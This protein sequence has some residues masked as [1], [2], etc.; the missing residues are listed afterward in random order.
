MSSYLSR[1][2]VRSALQ[3]GRNKFDLS[4][5]HLTTQDFYNMK[6]VYI[7][8]CI[9]GEKIHINMQAFTRLSPL[10]QPMLGS[11]RMVNRAFF[12]PMRTVIKFVHTFNHNASEWNL[13]F[14]TIDIYFY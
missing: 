9:P 13:R 3:R 11:V 12:V 2:K 1:I 10:V 8:E 14:D 6:P 5:S 4:C 7:H